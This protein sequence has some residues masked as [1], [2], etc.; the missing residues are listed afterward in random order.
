MPEYIDVSLDTSLAVGGNRRLRRQGI[1]IHTTEGI[2]SLAWLQGGSASAGRPA[3]ADFLITRKG[4][5]YQLTAPG[6]YAYHSG[7]ARW[8]FYQERDRTINQGFYGIELE[9]SRANEQKVTN[10]QYISLAFI[11][12]VL[13]SVY[14]IDVRNIVG[15]HQVALPVGRKQDP[16]GFVWEIFTRELINPSPDWSGY[17]LEGELP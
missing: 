9:N 11:V 14:P 1:V 12:R 8:A 3:S 15:H 17:V 2:N 7:Q 5:I 16:S 13:C 6:R 10:P 4:V